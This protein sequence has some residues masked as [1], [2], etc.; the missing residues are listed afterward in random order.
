M[1]TI[2]VAEPLSMS[3]E[4]DESPQPSPHK[5][6]Q[7]QQ[8]TITKLS[9]PISNSQK[10]QPSNSALPVQKR[11][12]VT[13]A[14]DEC[15]RKKIKCDGR[16]NCKILLSLMLTKTG[17]QPCTHCTVYS[18]GLPTLPCDLSL[19]AHADSVQNVHMTNLQTDDETQ[20]QHILKPSRAVCRK[21]KPF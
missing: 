3:S 16:A 7:D 5:R 10:D 17:K 21:Q 4:D 9:T 18:Y 20:L 8:E 1:A 13:R 6:L 12:R 14:C 2:P 11:R 19:T 15:R